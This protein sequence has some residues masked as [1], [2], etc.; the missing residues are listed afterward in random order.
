MR[1]GG[2]NGMQTTLLIFVQCNIL[3]TLTNAD[4]VQRYGP[5]PTDNLG[6]YGPGAQSPRRLP[7]HVRAGFEGLISP[8]S[9]TLYVQ[10]WT[11]VRPQA[12]YFPND[13]VRVGL[14]TNEDEI[15]AAIRNGSTNQIFNQTP[16]VKP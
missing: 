2:I 3:L 13:R 7:S 16:V 12:A 11:I 14:L 9:D 15:L 8:G 6:S 5:V 1:A 10:T 4:Y